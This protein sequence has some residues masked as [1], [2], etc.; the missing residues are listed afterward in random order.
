MIWTEIILLVLRLRILLTT[1]SVYGS[2]SFSIELFSIG[3][4]LHPTTVMRYIIKTFKL[5]TPLIWRHDAVIWQLDKVYVEITS[6]WRQIRLARSIKPHQLDCD[7]CHSLRM[8]KIIYFHWI[9]IQSSTNNASII[10]KD[11]L[12]LLFFSWEAFSNNL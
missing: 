3:A 8:S 2:Q 5:L 10:R 9:Y 12:P 6:S 11:A 4:N 7:Y 1:N